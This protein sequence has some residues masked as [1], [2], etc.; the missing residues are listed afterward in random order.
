MSRSSKARKTVQYHV[1][2]KFSQQ[3]KICEEQIL[4][5]FQT[6]YTDK[7]DNLLRISDEKQNSCLV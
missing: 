5:V 3:N 2:H 4:A 6:Y 1:V 7:R